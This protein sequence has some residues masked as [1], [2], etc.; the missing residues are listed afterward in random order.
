MA[1]IVPIACV[2]YDK[3]SKNISILNKK[4]DFYTVILSLLLIQEGQWSVSGEGKSTST[5]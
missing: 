1:C 5:G 3:I 4:M 2:F